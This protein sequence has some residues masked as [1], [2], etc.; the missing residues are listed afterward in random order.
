VSNRYSSASF[1]SAFTIAFFLLGFV[2]IGGTGCGRSGL[3]DYFNSDGGVIEGGPVPDTGPPDVSGCNPNT[4]PQGCCDG[5]GHCQPGTTTTACGELGEACQNCPAQGFSLCEATH[6]AC[7]N[8]VG[9]CGPGDCPTGCC[10]GTSQG[11]ICFA[12][13]DPNACGTGGQGCQQC[14]S[15]G[16]VCTGQQ[17]AKP[18]CGP[19]NCA[20]CCFGDQ[21]VGGGD[22]T[23]CGRNGQQCS[24]CLGQGE[25][26]ATS[27]GAPGGVCVP[28]PSCGPGC[29][30]CCDVNGV[31]ESGTLPNAC[32]AHGTACQNCSSFGEPCVNQQCGFNQGCGPWNCQGCCDS[33][34]TCQQGIFDNQ[35][36]QVGQACF[37]CEQQGEKCENQQCVPPTQA[38]NAQTCG[39]GCCDQFGFC[40]PG[41]SNNAC[42]GFG[43]FCTDCSAFG[44]SC[45]NQQCFVGPDGGGCNPGTCPNGCCDFAGNCQPGFA[46][47]ACGTFGQTC[48]N[49]LQFGEQCLNQQCFFI[50]PDSGID[51]AICSQTCAGCC[52]SAGNCLGGFLDKQCGSFGSTCEDCTALSPASTCDTAL[53]QRMCVSQQMQCP[54]P[55]PGCSPNL[56]QPIPVTQSGACSTSDLQQA[57][58]ACASGAMT[59]ACQQFYQ[60]EFQQNQNCGSCLSQFDYDF[61]QNVGVITCA[62]TFLDPTCN[63]N[64][65]CLLDCTNQA[66][67]QCPDQTTFG[68]CQTQTQASSGECSSYYQAE[69]CV[70]KALAGPASVCNPATYNNNFGAWL[71]GV[72]GQYC[73]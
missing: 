59:T 35:C 6:H 66:C 45:F 58:A 55:Y 32:G 9:Q 62:A 7:G 47:F 18:T 69:Q 64:S 8:P 4:C 52:D 63:H 41:F 5:A 65:A 61:N 31:C 60:F 10:E 27:P 48:Q 20:G 38:C 11:N 16:L 53:N 67:G 30:G 42:G 73:H 33:S 15:V 23:A 13:T 72:G 26:C 46:P 51:A 71:Q 70:T 43:G 29:Q 1:Q 12:G 56:T 68:Q 37:N 44:G 50:P 22:S 21:C 54:A 19:G 25:T 3:D 49:C 17:C 39:F 28:P 34:G 57:A 14:A 2:A 40:Q 36:G 24:N